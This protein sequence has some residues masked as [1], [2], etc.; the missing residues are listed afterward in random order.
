MEILITVSMGLVVYNGQHYLQL[1]TA[2]NENHYFAPI[3]EAEAIKISEADGIE[4]EVTSSPYLGGTMLRMPEPA[5]ADPLLD[6]QRR[7]DMLTGALEGGSNYWYYLKDD[8]TDIIDKYRIEDTKEPVVDIIWRAIKE[9]ESLP[10]RDLENDDLL[11]Y[12]SWNSMLAGEAK[13]KEEQ[14]EHYA[15]IIK[16]ND[17]AN[18]ADVW[19]QY[20]VMGTVVFG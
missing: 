14:T 2:T 7:L 8:A 1:I 15:D 10:V 3:T 17:D 4:I 12:I 16:E 18:T 9:G 19:F 20:V 11:G 13:M 5:V 6:D